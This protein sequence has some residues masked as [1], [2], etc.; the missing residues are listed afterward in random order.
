MYGKSGISGMNS[1]GTVHRGG[2]F[3]KENVIPSEVLSFLAFTGIPENFCTVCPLNYQC[4]AI[5][6]RSATPKMAASSSQSVFFCL[7]EEN[8]I[9]FVKNKIKKS[10]QM[11]KL[12]MF[13]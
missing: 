1:N 11:V 4:Q 7:R 8:A 3:S 12:V 9:P 10:I 13:S 6:E 5:S 2:K